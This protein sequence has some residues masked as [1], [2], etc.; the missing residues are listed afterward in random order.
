MTTYQGNVKLR[1]RDGKSRRNKNKK[2]KSSIF[3]SRVLVIFLIIV[4]VIFLINRTEKP[5]IDQHSENEILTTDQESEFGPSLTLTGFYQILE[6]GFM[7][8]QYQKIITTIVGY[9]IKNY[10]DV[11]Q[12]S[13]LPETFRAK[14]I[15][16]GV[17]EFKYATDNNKLYNVYLDT[18]QTLDDIEI[19]IIPE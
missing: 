7:N 2:K 14:N 18:K 6:C 9:M 17:Y 4:L 8:V 1:K 5:V 11:T 10:P 19:E 13:F 15:E 3:A 12:I 16:D